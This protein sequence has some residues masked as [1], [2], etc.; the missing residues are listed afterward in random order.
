MH[1]K[2]FSLSKQILLEELV[3]PLFPT[4]QG[5]VDFQYHLSEQEAYR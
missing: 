1:F 4:K 3:L 2:F 5:L